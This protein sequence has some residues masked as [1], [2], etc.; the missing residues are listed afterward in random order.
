MDEKRE[1]LLKD[2]IFKLMIKL[3]VP[4]IIGMLVIGLYS[5]V[6][7][8]FVGRLVGS[9]ALAAVSVTYPLTLINNGI[10]V[11][12]GIGSASVLS[13][14]IGSNDIK[15][16]DDI[17]SNMSMCNIVLSLLVTVI[18]VIFTDYLIG[19]TGLSGDIFTL[20]K[21][22][23]R[24]IF[25]GSIFVN[26]VQSA[27][28]IIRGEGK[29][30]EAMLIMGAGAILNIILDPIFIKVL[31]LGIRGA[32]YATVLS[33]IMQ[34]IMTL[35]YFKKYSNM[36]QLKKPAF[37]KEVLPDVLSVGFSAMLMQVMTLVQQT[38]LYRMIT[39]YGN[40]QQLVIMGITMRVTMFSFI[41]IWGMSQGL[42]P[43]AGINYGAKK[44]DRVKKSVKM[45]SIG[46]TG[47]CLVFWIP[48]QLAP[49]WILSLFTK[50][51]MLIEYGFEYFKLGNMAFFVSG[52]FIMSIT[53]FQAI[54]KAGSAGLIIMLRQ[55][56]LFIPLTLLLA[57]FFGG[58]GVWYS[59]PITD[60]I[61]F[62]TAMCLVI[63]E[64]RKTLHQEA[65][66]G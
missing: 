10:A 63:V 8:I 3:S 18:G 5:F 59:I 29:M 46:A 66:F 21:A 42:Q 1:E 26:F 33:Q 24:I 53:F 17:M 34:M 56:A 35:V 61:V 38:I 40:D 57:K 54:G 55:I 58:I 47:L 52:I 65:S 9:E 6:D 51:Q 15:K 13:R 12:I 16:I 27:N 64:F 11:L 7:A 50:D 49:K 4:A 20:A 60:I 32:A 44:F 41:P 25:V 22:Y 45:F 23:L 31:N 37:K 48:M 19:F 14:A 62:I 43:I 36:V 28:M 39:I 2:S 30:K